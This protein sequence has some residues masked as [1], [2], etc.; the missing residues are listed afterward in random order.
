MYEEKATLD[1]LSALNAMGVYDYDHHMWGRTWP[2]TTPPICLLEDASRS[3]NDGGYILWPPAL[4]L[5][6]FCERRTK[7][8]VVKRLWSWGQD[9]ASRP[10]CATTNNNKKRTL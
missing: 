5:A 9:A 7:A 1:K 2:A 8:V 3:N 4:T 10:W 6:K